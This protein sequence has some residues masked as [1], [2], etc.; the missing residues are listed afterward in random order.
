MLQMPPPKQK[1]G[2]GDDEKEAANV[3]Y[4]YVHLLIMK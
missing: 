4:V 3:K 2:P 1:H